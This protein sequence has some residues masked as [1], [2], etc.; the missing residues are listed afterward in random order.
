MNDI[1]YY[2]EDIKRRLAEG[3]PV[4]PG[5]T[6]VQDI[7]NLN[8]P[9]EDG[10]EVVCT[11]TIQ[12]EGG[13]GSLVDNLLG[14]IARST[15]V[16]NGAFNKT[17]TVICPIKHDGN[18]SKPRIPD[19]FKALSTINS[20]SIE[21]AFSGFN[22]IE[23]SNNVDTF[24]ILRGKAFSTPC[25]PNIIL[26][27]ARSLQNPPVAYYNRGVVEQYSIRKLMDENDGK[28]LIFII[29]DRIF[30]P[31]LTFTT[32]NFPGLRRLAY[33]KGE[34]SFFEV[35]PLHDPCTGYTSGLNHSEIYPETSANTV[36]MI[37]AFAKL[38]SHDR[39]GY[40][41][42]RLCTIVINARGETDGLKLPNDD[43]TNR[44]A[45]I[46]RKIVR[47]YDCGT[48]TLDINMLCKID[49]EPYAVDSTM[50]KDKSN[51][52][53][54]ERCIA[55]KILR[56][57]HQS[58]DGSRL[59]ELTVTSDKKIAQESLKYIADFVMAYIVSTKRVRQDDK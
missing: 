19:V 30:S 26:I 2:E 1:R 31:Q 27:D 16:K 36:N 15:R 25:S 11:C 50:K 9:S 37:R 54:I 29:G 55:M 57:K 18:V 59:M 17:V 4:V 14:I 10:K 51:G 3:L 53:L 12:S 13:Q 5:E 46:V 8:L 52:N 41:P 24:V 23:S 28:N 42:D 47:V 22:F 6:D 58:E 39:K 44:L 21:S 40:D 56:G 48:F 32:N 49:E 20:D 7:L 45:S 34:N 38:N 35:S 33:V 43:F